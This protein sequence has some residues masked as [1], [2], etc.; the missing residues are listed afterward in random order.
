MALRVGCVACPDRLLLHPHPG[1][2]RESLRGPQLAPCPGMAFTAGPEPGDRGGA[3]RALGVPLGSRDLVGPLRS[4][5]AGPQLLA[6]V[7]LR[8]LLAWARGPASV[9]FGERL[10]GA[11]S[12]A[13]HREGVLR[14]PAPAGRPYPEAAVHLSRAARALAGGGWNPGLHLAGT[15]L[16]DQRLPGGGRPAATAAIAALVY[17]AYT[18]GGMALFGIESWLDR[19]EAFSAY[20]GMFSRLAVFEVRE[21]RLGR[22]GSSPECRAGR[23]MPG[24]VALVIV[25]IGGTTF[26]GAQEGF[27]ASPISG[28]G[29]GC[30]TS[31]SAQRW[32]F[33]STNRSTW[34]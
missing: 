5:H 4:G 33:A 28:S 11:E 19:G 15:G 8:H 22:G 21:G 34:H 2:A 3:R 14:V 29:T 26:D 20:F 23:M 10:P 9:L 31:V 17:S 1:V 30:W 16:R 24:S 32:R 18:L 6:H 12:L 13:R 7:L 27:L 25:T